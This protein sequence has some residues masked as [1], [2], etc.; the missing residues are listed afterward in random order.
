MHS[1]ILGSVNALSSSHKEILTNI[2]QNQV[3]PSLNSSEISS[4]SN[5]EQINN[6]N[7]D[8]SDLHILI[9][10]LKNEIDKLKPHEIKTMEP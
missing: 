10:Q 4:I 7:N 9:L 3:L 1:E 6:I 5:S 8:N 2:N